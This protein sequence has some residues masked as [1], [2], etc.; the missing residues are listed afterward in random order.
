MSARREGSTLTATGARGAPVSTGGDLSPNSA[1]GRLI[2]GWR[3]SFASDDYLP[4]SA[5]AIPRVRAVLE[6]LAESLR[7][8]RPPKARG[9][10]R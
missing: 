4:R 5:R 10:R 2:P 1:L 8:W 7:A 3:P 6:P 9:A